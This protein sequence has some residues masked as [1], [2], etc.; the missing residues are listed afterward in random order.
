M[1]NYFDMPKKAKYGSYSPWIK[2]AIALSGK[3]D[4]FPNL[5]IPRMTAEY[6][7]KKGFVIEDSA[8][9]SLSAAIEK[10]VKKK[11]S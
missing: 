8:S 3:V 11:R 1:G 7:I 5:N 6:W 4:L 2:A 9:E 10:N